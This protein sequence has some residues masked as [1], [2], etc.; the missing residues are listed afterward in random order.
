M[1]KVIF[2]LTIFLMS[3]NF[4]YAGTAITK[5]SDTKVQESVDQPPAIR[6][7]TL[8]QAM[9]L[10]AKRHAQADEADA[11]VAAMKAL[12]VVTAADAQSVLVAQLKRKK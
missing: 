10:A 1:K 2:I 4:S 11:R 7:I 9:A 3:E 6:F 8:D 5:V 12:G